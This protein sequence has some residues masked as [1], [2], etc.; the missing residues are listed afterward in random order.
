MENEQKLA[1]EQEAPGIPALTLEGLEPPAL[2]LE[3]EAPP[4]EK[5][6]EATTLDESA[7]TPEEQKAPWCC[8]TAPRPR[9]K[10]RPFPIRR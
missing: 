9:R 3:P 10:S 5:K 1:L 2:T 6:P 4:E 8:N 7:L